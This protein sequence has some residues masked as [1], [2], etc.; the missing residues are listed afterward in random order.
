MED[1]EGRRAKR[2]K[3]PSDTTDD[4]PPECK[5]CAAADDDALV[6]HCSH[7][8]FELQE[9]AIGEGGVRRCGPI[10]R[11][12]AVT[13]PRLA[14]RAGLFTHVHTQ[15]PR[16]R[17]CCLC[18]RPRHCRSQFGEVF[19]ARQLNGEDAGRTVA[20]KFST[21]PSDDGERRGLSKRDMMGSKLW[22]NLKREVDAMEKAT[23]DTPPACHALHPASLPGRHM[24]ASPPPLASPLGRPAHA[25]PDG[26][27]Q[28]KRR[29]PPPF[30]RGRPP[31]AR[32]WR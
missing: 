32:W 3:R 11:S 26:R 13:R 18:G 15:T 8:D 27:D 29:P 4:T 6:F 14:R 7:G 10:P 1:H 5:I 31:A 28:R 12:G 9:P 23:V 19:K 17:A 30:R 16:V 24:R 20:I 22:R 25:F 21:T 2:E